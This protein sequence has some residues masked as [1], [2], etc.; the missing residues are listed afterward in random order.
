MAPV[1]AAAAA[2]PAPLIPQGTPTVRQPQHTHPPTR[3]CGA[4][5]RPRVCLPL[6]RKQQGEPNVQLAYSRLGR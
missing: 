6:N 2:L 1:P 4:V 3:V 5:H